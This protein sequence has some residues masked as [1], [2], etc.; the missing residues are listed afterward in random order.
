MEAPDTLVFDLDPGPDVGWGQIARYSI[1]AREG[2]PLATP[3]RWDELTTAAGANRYTVS[4]IRRR[5]SALKEDPWEGYEQ[6]RTRVTKSMR[7][8]V[9][10]E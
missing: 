6:A 1:R 7:K 9:G 3:L 2:A 10:E 8:Q 5:L 4:N